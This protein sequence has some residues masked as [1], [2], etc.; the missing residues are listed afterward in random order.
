MVHI[1]PLGMYCSVAEALKKIQMR[2]Q[3]Y[4]LDW[5]V[6]FGGISDIFSNKFEDFI[7]DKK[8]V[9]PNGD[10]FDWS[11]RYG[12]IF[13]HDNFP[14]S[15]E[16]YNRRIS[17]MLDILNTTNDL[18]VFV[19]S[20]HSYEHH[21]EIAHNNILYEDDMKDITAFD[22]VIKKDYPNLKYRIITILACNKCHKDKPEALSIGNTCFYNISTID[23]INKDILL[24]YLL[25]KEIS[26][27]IA[28]QL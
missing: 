14:E 16:K 2:Q 26:R 9:Y 20:C 24:P 4:P 22:S 15:T 28:L 6:S 23:N 10:N 7:P 11:K 3:S 19:R 12:L 17:R 27:I 13:R 5:V 21:D 8:Y 18:V 1:I 25:E